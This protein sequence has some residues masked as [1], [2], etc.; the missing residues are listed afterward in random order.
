MSTVLRFVETAWGPC[1]EL[2]ASSA[3][4]WILLFL[5][6]FHSFSGFS[7]PAL[8]FF[9]FFFHACPWKALL[10]ALPSDWLKTVQLGT[11]T[12][13]GSKNAEWLQIKFIAFTCSMALYNFYLAWALGLRVQARSVSTV[14]EWLHLRSP[15]FVA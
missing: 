1:P 15:R 3:E 7:N 11:Q 12:T 13:M 2:Q 10:W 5:L 4:C 9:F 6:R 8:L 14:L